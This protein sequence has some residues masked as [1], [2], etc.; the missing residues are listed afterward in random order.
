MCGLLA[1]WRALSA[2]PEDL[3]GLA[4]LD[5]LA[6]RYFHP[7]LLLLAFFALER[8]HTN[9]LGAQAPGALKVVVDDLAHALAFFRLCLAN[10]AGHIFDH[11]SIAV[12]E[13]DAVNDLLDLSILHGP[14]ATVVVRLADLVHCI[15]GRTFEA[16]AWATPLAVHWNPTSHHSTSTESHSHKRTH[17][18]T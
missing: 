4:D 11:R 12:A 6:L 2:S 9:A 14:T 16:M 3:D 5:L 10:G 1:P 15:N 13:L 8:G 18:R 7:K 17:N